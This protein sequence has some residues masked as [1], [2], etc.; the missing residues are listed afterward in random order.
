MVRRLGAMVL[1]WCAAFGGGQAFAG[2][3]HDY[4]SDLG[5]MWEVLWHQS[6]TPTRLVRWE[7]ELRVRIH[8]IDLAQHRAATLAAVQAVA[9]ETGV[10]VVDVSAAPDAAARANVDI[11]IVANDKLDANEPCVTQ[12]HYQTET[13][14]D[15]ANVLMRTGDAA[16]CA[17]HEMMHVMGLR[18]HPSGRTVLS[19]FEGKTDG[20][21]PLDRAML[22]AW[23][24]PK[25]RAGMTPFEILP[26]MAEQHGA[27]VADAAKAAEVRQRFYART[28]QDMH[29]FVEGHGQ[30][31]AIIARSGKI[32]DVGLRWGRMEMGYF[33]GLAYSAGACVTADA[34]RSAEWLR[35]AATM[36]NSAARTRLLGARG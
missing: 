11:Q 2:A 10:R 27:S 16:R 4:E 23:Y 20:L 13:R 18:G 26:V 5:T 19:Y 34:S 15:A 3:T 31:P 6:G 33:L 8:G 32:T 17:H 35:R 7:Q 12:L 24:S 9:A 22:K 1:A 30:A 14:I 29:A 21:L 25:A 28:V 36:G